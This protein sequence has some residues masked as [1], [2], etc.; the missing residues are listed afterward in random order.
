MLNHAGRLSMSGKEGQVPRRLS[1]L[2]VGAAALAIIVFVLILHM[3]SDDLTDHRHM[4]D[5]TRAV[6]PAPEIDVRPTIAKLWKV[7]RRCS[8]KIYAQGDAEGVILCLL[9]AVGTD[10]RFFVEFGYPYVTMRSPPNTLILRVLG[11]W[12]GFTLDGDRRWNDTSTTNTTIHNCSSHFVTPDN[13][14]ELFRVRGTPFNLDYLSI[15]IDSRD[16]WV[17]RS[18][19]ECGYRPRIIQVEY[20]SN[21]PLGRALSFPRNSSALWRKTCHYGASLSAFLLLGDEFQYVPVHAVPALDI[22]FVR[23]DLVRG[24]P[25]PADF[26]RRYT[27]ITN[28]KCA[29]GIDNFTWDDVSDVTSLQQGR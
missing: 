13:I 7:L 24:R 18:L 10:S 11:G 2:V 22:I 6:A 3:F 29:G 23:R 19:L 9:S 26:W 27:N 15:D 5:G 12:K 4:Q 20:N 25:V 21:I 16:Y 17:L 28:H 1:S 8:H 14:C